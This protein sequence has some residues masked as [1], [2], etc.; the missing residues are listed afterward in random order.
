MKQPF[1]L[2]LATT[3]MVCLTPSLQAALSMSLYESDGNVIL[4]GTGSLDL[5]PKVVTDDEGEETEHN[6]TKF[7]GTSSAS[8]KPSDANFV[9]GSSSAQA[10]DIYYFNTADDIGII[11]PSSYGAGSTP[12]TSPDSH[13]GNAPFGLSKLLGSPRISVPDGY[14]SGAALSGTSTWNSTTLAAME[15]TE[16]TYQWT[17]L[18]G[19]TITL[20]VGNAVPEPS[21]YA[22]SLAFLAGAALLRINRKKK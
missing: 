12:F 2:I 10:V 18:S 4:A 13:T 9:L 17:I 11:G 6:Y 22:F 3:L 8:I 21:T 20:T 15:A 1:Q 16:G 5:G 19:D 7:D 14:V